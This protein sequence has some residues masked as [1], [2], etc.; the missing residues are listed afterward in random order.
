MR[1]GAT[2]TAAAKAHGVTVERLRRHRQQNTASRYV[3]GVWDIYDHRPQAF[4]LI[5]DGQMTSVTMPNEEGSVI[6]GYL[7]AVNRFLYSNDDAL[8]DPFEG[9]GVVDVR[10]RF[11]QFETRPNVLRKLEAMGDLNFIEIYADGGGL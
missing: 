6:S 7:H 3:R 2:Q 4:W 1:H 9:E 11:H 8:L 5:S 10:G